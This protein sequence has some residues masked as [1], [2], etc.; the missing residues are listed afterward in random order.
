MSM[1]PG[2]RPGSVPSVAEPLRTSPAAEATKARNSPSTAGAVTSPRRCEPLPQKSIS[3]SATLTTETNRFSFLRFARIDARRDLLSV[4]ADLAHHPLQARLGRVVEE[5][6]R[7]GDAG[8][9]GGD[10]F[11]HRLGDGAVG[12]VALAAGAQLDQ[13]HRLA[14]VQVE[15][16][17]DTEGEAE[18]IWRQLIEAGRGQP[19]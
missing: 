4:R 16:V 5:L 15:D 14:R 12:G 17:A 6:H 11:V 2:I 19:L 7:R 18:G 1:L 10:S 9:D 3:R 8:V 13:V